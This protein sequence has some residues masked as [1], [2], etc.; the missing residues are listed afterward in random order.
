MIFE[1]TGKLSIS[2]ETDK[3][4][5]Y[6]EKKFPSGWANKRLLFNVTC[7]DNRHMMNVQAGAW[8]DGHGDV[9]TYSKSSADESGNKVK[10]EP[11]RIPFKERLTSPKIA[12]VAEFRKFIVDLEKPQRRYKLQN[13]ADKLH[14]G[15]EIT[16]EQLKEVGLT[17]KDEIAEALEKSNKKRHEFISQWDFVDFIKKVIDSGK[18]NNSKF[19]IRGNGDYSYSDKNQRAYESYVPTRIYLAADDAEESAIGTI[20][21][22]FNKDSLDVMS[23]E[24]KE[25]YFVNGYMMEY[26]NNR[27]SNIP[28]QT[29]I[30]IPI[31]DDEKG[32]KKAEAIKHKFMLEEDDESFKE[33][34]MLVNM[35]NGAQ[36][37]EITE[38]MLTDEQKSDLKY[39]IITM[40][41]I[42]DELGG[43]VYGERIRE[44][45]FVK[46]ARGFTKGRQDTVYT[47]DDMHV[48][49]L[50]SEDDDNL[51]DEETVDEDDEL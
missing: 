34:G 5:P 17:S 15:G 24:E 40:D 3:F 46:P 12:E 10:G 29:T 19:F 13:I 23:A 50:E 25:K 28:V 41:D 8:A 45:Q 14:E 18:Y 43:S 4:K 11:L 47:E 39:G 35:I 51:F 21:L 33:Y 32:K 16:D 22:I 44:Y 48:K 6:E 9:Y 49:P 26:D 38:D 27:K 20:N 7:G 31:P 30:V 36:R 1:M 2:K 42:R 37:Q